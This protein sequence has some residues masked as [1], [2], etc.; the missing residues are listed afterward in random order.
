LAESDYHHRFA[1]VELQ[2]TDEA[3]RKFPK[4]EIRAKLS[5]HGELEEGL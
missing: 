1:I 4:V 5:M 2:G 3:P